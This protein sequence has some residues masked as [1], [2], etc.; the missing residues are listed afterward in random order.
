LVGLKLIQYE[1]WLMYLRD[2]KRYG[3]LKFPD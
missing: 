1:Q 2:S 3:N